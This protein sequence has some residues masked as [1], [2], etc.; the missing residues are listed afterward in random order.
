MV[1]LIE[2]DREFTI[3]ITELHDLGETGFPHVDLARQGR[4][5]DWAHV[6]D[7]KNSD[8]GKWDPILITKTSIGY[9]LLGGYHRREAAK[10]KRKPEVTALNA[11][12]RTFKDERDVINS[13]FEDNATHGLK[14]SAQTKSDHAYF[15]WVAYPGVYTHKEIALKCGISRTGVSHAIARKTPKTEEAQPTE[16]GPTPGAEPP[17][18]KSPGAITEEARQEKGVAPVIRLGT[19]PDEE[20]R[21]LEIIKATNALSDDTQRLLEYLHNV[22]QDRLRAAGITATLES[23]HKRLEESMHIID[24]ILHPP[25]QEIPGE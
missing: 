21:R 19:Q 15:L 14:P 11:I 4:Q 18:E 12:C 8:H 16:P 20:I 1:E 24:D 13:V 25:Q 23:V 2:E 5:I 10:K 3:N 17:K 6:E 9:V 7:L 22:E